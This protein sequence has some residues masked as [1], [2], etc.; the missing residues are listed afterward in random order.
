MANKKT[1]FSKILE[2]IVL[3][4]RN[5]IIVRESAAA[6]LAYHVGCQALG[7]MKSIPP[8]KSWYASELVKLLKENGSVDLYV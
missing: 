8:D 4:D 6:I 1:D 2:E 5:K 7:I 3:D